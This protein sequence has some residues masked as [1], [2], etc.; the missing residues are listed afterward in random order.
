MGPNRLTSSSHRQN[1]ASYLNEELGATNRS[2][3]RAC[4]VRMMRYK[5]HILRLYRC[6]SAILCSSIGDL[7]LV[8]ASPLPTY[9]WPQLS[10][11]CQQLPMVVKRLPQYAGPHLPV[12]SSHLRYMAIYGLPRRLI[13]VSHIFTGTSIEKRESEDVFR[14]VLKVHETTSGRFPL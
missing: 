6:E 5:N 8:R 9:K 2:E 12:G 14:Y 11:Y 3:R 1:S 13:T 10:N 7:R 4:L